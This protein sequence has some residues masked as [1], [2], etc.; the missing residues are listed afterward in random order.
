MVARALEQFVDSIEVDGDLVKLS[1]DD[2]EV[3]GRI[4]RTDETS[5]LA[6]VHAL[7]SVL[8][9]TDE[10]QLALVSAPE[11]T[12]AVETQLEKFVAEHASE[13]AWGFVDD[14]GDAR[15]VIPE[16]DLDE[17][18]RNVI[19][20]AGAAR[21]AL[22]THPGSV[23]VGRN[24]SLFTD[25]NQWLLKVLILN[26]AP[27]EVWDRPRLE[28]RGPADLSRTDWVDVSQGK[29]YQFAHTLKDMGY[30]V[31]KRGTFRLVEV[32]NLL[33]SWL[34]VARSQRPFRTPVRSLLGD[35]VRRVFKS[36][37]STQYALAGALAAEA[38][39]LRHVSES[40]EEV[41]VFDAVDELVEEAML[42]VCED[43][44]AGFYLIRPT[45][46]AA[47]ERAVQKPADHTVVDLV[48]VALDASRRRARGQEQAEF[49][50]SKIVS[51]FE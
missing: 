4:E 50:V 14:A 35:D 22:T 41:Y 21:I 7:S 5:A 38:Y 2:R 29:A 36:I 20:E 17:R 40:I 34:A 6:V 37:S 8:L 23:T 13:R 46:R 48:Q 1:R 45:D 9:Q 47:V 12:R 27:P 15:L 49:V 51:W 43:A 3:V 10:S 19:V 32:E 16:Y 18:K 31:W 42:E 11:V 28:L 26:H 44:R 33:N 30:L 24:Q 39:G 25:L